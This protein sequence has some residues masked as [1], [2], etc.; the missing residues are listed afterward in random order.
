MPK[1]A[2]PRGDSSPGG[3]VPAPWLP[4]PPGP[5][6]QVHRDG[7]RRPARPDPV[8]SLRMEHH[9]AHVQNR[10]NCPT[11]SA[12]INSTAAVESGRSSGTADCL[13]IDRRRSLRSR[14]R[15]ARLLHIDGHD[16]PAVARAA[17]IARSAGIP[18][19]RIGHHNHGSTGSCRRWTTQHQLRISRPLEQ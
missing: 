19:P 13:R 17:R 11:Q 1:G 8:D 5:A 10:K 12:Y 6:H 7:R 18:S 9:L 2:V 14:S 15:C 3:Q 16:T 4:R